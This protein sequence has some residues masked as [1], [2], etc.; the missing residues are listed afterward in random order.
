MLSAQH[1]S[2]RTAAAAAS[3][4]LLAGLLVG[5]LSWP[6]A[7]SA[8]NAT[9]TVTAVNSA[10][11]YGRARGER[12]AAAVYDRDTGQWWTSGDV[13]SYYA[14]AS[15]VK[16]FI[17]ARLLLGGQMRG[18][19]A[20]T[21]ARMIEYSDDDAATSLY[22]RVGGDSLYQW[23]RARFHIPVG[24]PPDAGYWGETR[25]TAAGMVSFYNQMAAM[26]AGKWLMTAMGHYSCT[27]A[28]GWPQ[29]FGIPAAAGTHPRIK[30]GWMCCL[31]NKTRMHSTGYVD[32][33]HIIVAILTEGSRSTYGA[34]A[35][36]TVTNMA[37]RMMPGGHVPLPYSYGT[38][39][40]DDPP[41]VQPGSLLPTSAP[42]D[43][44][45]TSAPADEPPTSAPAD[46]PPTT[47][48]PAPANKPADKPTSTA[49]TS[50]T[51]STSGAATPTGATSAQSTADPPPES[52]GSSTNP[53]TAGSTSGQ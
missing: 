31:E 36:D 43:E 11:S 24:P 34:Y 26:S 1:I 17:A 20:T 47:A 10:V 15:V 41:I 37:K 9:P 45:P 39:D 29:C 48:A 25:I 42:T 22:G 40:V 49:S 16:A 7:S 5:I 23:V 33:D 28:D 51:S 50:T 14:S 4:V 19:I 30:Q 27:A 8:T 18:S 38:P 21:A 12:V 46:E 3:V 52:S 2:R 6:H 53:A 13:N 32:S 35:R 44:P